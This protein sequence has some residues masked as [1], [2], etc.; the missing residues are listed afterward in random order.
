[1]K[2]YK[3]LHKYMLLF[4]FLGIAGCGADY[5]DIEHIERAKDFQDKG[6]LVSAIIELKNAANKNPNNPEARLLL[7]RIYLLNGSADVAE[8]EL[9]RAIKLGITDPQVALDL[10]ESIYIQGDFNK[11]ISDLDLNKYASEGNLSRAQA[12]LGNAYLEQGNLELSRSL[13]EKSV[14]L[15]DNPSARAG[16]IKIKILHGGGD[17]T[18]VNLNKALAS[19]PKSFDLNLVAGDYY[20]NTKD[21]D[22][23]IDYYSKAID[24][25]ENVNVILRRADLYVTT[26]KNQLAQVDVDSVL[27]LEKGHPLANFIKGKISYQQKQ[28]DEAKNHFE[29]VLNILPNHLQSIALLGVVNFNLENF[30]Q[31]VNALE[32]YQHQAPG[33]P[34]IERLLAE[35]YIRLGNGELAIRLLENLAVKNAEDPGLYQMLGDAYLLNSDLTKAKQN[36]SY[37][38]ELNPREAASVNQL[39]ILNILTGESQV[40]AKSLEQELQGTQVNKQGEILLIWALVQSGQYDKAMEYARLG[41]EK[42]PDDAQRLFIRGVIHQHQADIEQ[43]KSD[44]NEAL[45]KDKEFILSRIGLAEIA[46]QEK[47]YAEAENQF[48]QVLSVKPNHLGSLMGLALIGDKRGDSTSTVAWLQKARELVP[49]ASEPVEAL[50]NIYINNGEPDRAINI[51]QQYE[52]KNKKSQKGIILSAKALLAGGNL[53]GVEDK[54]RHYLEL[55]PQDIGTRLY[56]VEVL[57]KQPDITAAMR[58]I[59][60]LIRQNED[61]PLLAAVKVRLLLQAN[62]VKD[63]KEIIKSLA[64]SAISQAVYHEL[65]G[66]VALRENAVEKAFSLYK[67]AYSASENYGL[68]RKLSILALNLNQTKDVDDQLQNYISKN[69]SYLDARILRASFLEKQSR[70]TD[71]KSEYHKVLEVDKNNLAALNNLANLHVSVGEFKDALNF[72]ERAYKLRGTSPEVMDTYGWA[73][74]Q[75]EQLEEGLAFLK[76]AFEKLPDNQEVAYH[77]AVA[78]NRLGKLAELKDVVAKITNPGYQELLKS[79]GIK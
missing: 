25:R 11:I 62:Q 78:L 3:A 46:M 27:Q 58:E 30:E 4:V 36:L 21:F 24:I 61:A 77:I 1:M 48:K 52:N 39:A 38:N 9:A 37:A 72:A 43:A 60:N 20:L 33:N 57:S 79:E 56:L 31:A 10:F 7:G 16:L 40:A 49:N 69:P 76:K 17:E 22:R 42:E 23:A 67:Q 55:Y 66:D 47:Q 53:L 71:A 54:L 70:V 19:F 29:Q 13:L 68:L 14:A 34:D 18:L 6:D 26:G 8:K 28:F 74:V 2:N 44:F 65:S 63:A 59:D 32:K 51:A 15:Q 5:T 35:S 12:L 73:L 64:G 45:T 50:V 75:N 41:L